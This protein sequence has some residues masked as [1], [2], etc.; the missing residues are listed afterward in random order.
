MASATPSAQ[1]PPSEPT[2]HSFRSQRLTLRYVQWGS[3]GNPP[4]ILVH[5]GRDHCRSW[6]WLARALCPD[7]HLHAPDLRGHGDSEWSSSGLYTYDAYVWDLLAFLDHLK[8]DRV[9]LVGHSLGGNIALRL[10]AAFPE[11]VSRLV[12]I[13]G[14]GSNPEALQRES[15]THPVDLARELALHRLAL[16]GEEDPGFGRI[17]EA[18]ARMRDKHDYLDAAQAR[19]LVE[20]GTRVG[21]DGRLHW[22]FDPGVRRTVQRYQSQDEIRLTCERVECP[23]LLPWGGKSFMRI[24]ANRERVKWFRDARMVDFPECGHWLQHQELDRLVGEIREFLEPLRRA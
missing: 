8:L 10:A 12:C 19:H 5:G 6:D 17:D 9:A 4:L 24:D 1:Q 21:A 14:L 2:Q 15:Q 20:H 22:K 3:A 11:R 13:E 18:V 7:W 16:D 23:V